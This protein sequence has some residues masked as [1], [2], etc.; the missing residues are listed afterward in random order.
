VEGRGRGGWC[1]STHR[2]PMTTDT[3][4]KQDDYFQMADKQCRGPGFG[5]IWPPCP[6]S[7]FSPPVFSP[8]PTVASYAYLNKNFNPRNYCQNKINLLPLN[9]VFRIRI[10][11]KFVSWIRIRIP[12]VDPDPDPAADKISSKSQ[13]NSYHLEIFD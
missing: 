6:F 9:T 4:M 8:G 13:N 7:T 10:R 2:C 5:R 3:Y 11:I 12:N 1:S